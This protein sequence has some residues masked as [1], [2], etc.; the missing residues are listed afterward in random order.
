LKENIYF[1][2]LE[3]KVA[4]HKKW[5]EKLLNPGNSMFQVAFLVSL[6]ICGMKNWEKRYLWIPETQQKILPFPRF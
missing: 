3:K 4:K 1:L 2:R 5:I 6:D